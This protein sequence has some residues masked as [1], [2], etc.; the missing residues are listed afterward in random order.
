MTRNGRHN[1]SSKSCTYCEPL[2]E[3]LAYECDDFS[4]A[5]GDRQPTGPGYAIFVPK[6]HVADL[7]SWPAEESERLLT[8]IRRVCRAV[9]GAFGVAGTTVVLN[10]G[11]PAQ[12]IAHLHAHIIPRRDGDGYP[13]VT[14]ELISADELARQVALLGDGMRTRRR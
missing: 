7:H 6:K 13:R 12:R 5:V 1:L 14:E 11:P 8:N 10:V 4:V 2:G 3:A 9:E